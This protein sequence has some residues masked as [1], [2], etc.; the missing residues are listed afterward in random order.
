MI[1]G[2]PIATK[3]AEEP[4]IKRSP[5]RAEIC[6]LKSLAIRPGQ[7]TAFGELLYID[8]AAAKQRQD[9]HVGNLVFA[10]EHLSDIGG[11]LWFHEWC[12]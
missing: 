4:R 11:L 2:H 12:G 7:L 9:V 3:T 1:K 5:R 8:S 10:G 6:A